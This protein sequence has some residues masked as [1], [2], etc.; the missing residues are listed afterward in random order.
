MKGILDGFGWTG[1]IEKG[2]GLLGFELPDVVS[3]GLDIGREFFGGGGKGSGGID[4]SNRYKRAVDL[5]AS[6]M[7]TTRM[8]GVG[9]T[10][11]SAAVE[12][13]DELADMLRI[14]RLYADAE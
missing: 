1:L 8:V 6:S 4:T 11:A 12:Y 10:K 3:T 9:E 7:G 5:G 2:A 14:V 13:E